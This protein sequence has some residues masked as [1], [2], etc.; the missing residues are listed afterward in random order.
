MKDLRQ[1]L[2]DF[3]KWDNPDSYRIYPVKVEAKVDEYLKSINGNERP[4]RELG[5]NKGE[6]FYCYDYQEGDSK[7]KCKSQC[8]F[9]K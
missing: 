3:I 6:D 4:Q 9:C 5:D 7:N 2:I 8:H 1:E